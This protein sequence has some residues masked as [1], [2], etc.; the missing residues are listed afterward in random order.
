VCLGQDAR[1]A[2]KAAKQQYEYQLAH[3]KRNWLNQ[4]ALT[5]VERVQYEQ[6]LDATHVGLG[7]AYA[8]LQEKFRDQIAAAMQESESDFQQ[9]MQQ[10][11]GANLAASGRTGRSIDRISTV[12]LGQYLAK[13]SRKAYE[14]TQSARDISK[15]QAQA[16]AQARHAQMSAFAKANIT[17]SP[18]LAPPKPVYQNVGMAQ[19]QD[20]LKIGGA[21]AGI[22]T[23]LGPGGAG[24]WTN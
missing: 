9:Y 6:T 8:E 20:A 14:L 16:H 24:L 1:N 18:D 13:G 4:L 12:E 3:R 2:N 23:G 17:K 22:A 15:E 5:N 11:V 7:N 21:V 10:S 19:F